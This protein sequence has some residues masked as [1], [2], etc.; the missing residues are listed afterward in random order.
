[1]AKKKKKNSQD[2]KRK[3]TKKNSRV[4]EYEIM[5]MMQACLKQAI[6]ATLDELL[7]E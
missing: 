7:K 5:K 3:I 4:L 2:S 1:M 6:D